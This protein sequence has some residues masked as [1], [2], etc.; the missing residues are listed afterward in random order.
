[1]LYR[2]AFCVFEHN[3]Q[4]AVCESG[5]CAGGLR[6]LIPKHAMLDPSVSGPPVRL[7]SSTNTQGLPLKGQLYRFRRTQAGMV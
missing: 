2:P 6:I 5:T 1:M 7:S 4:V 3:G